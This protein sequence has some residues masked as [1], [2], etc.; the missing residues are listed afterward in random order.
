MRYELRLRPAGEWNERLVNVGYA[1][2]LDLNKDRCLYNGISYVFDQALS[3][4]DLGSPIDY[5]YVDPHTGKPLGPSPR[6][7][8]Q[9]PVC[10][11]DLRDSGREWVAHSEQAAA[12][13]R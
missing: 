13:L 1:P 7:Q 12:E 4:I 11:C 9:K 3:E 6:S 2:D 5:G 10:R 8:P